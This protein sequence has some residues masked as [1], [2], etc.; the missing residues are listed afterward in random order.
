MTNL[1]NKKKKIP[2]TTRVVAAV[3]AM[4]FKTAL[5]ENGDDIARISF[6]DVVNGLKGEESVNKRQKE[7][8]RRK[9]K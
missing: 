9:R 5:F 8:R 7:C 2:T 4:A 6:R 3:A 1:L